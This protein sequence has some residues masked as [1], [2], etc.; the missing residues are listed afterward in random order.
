MA[1]ETFVLGFCFLSGGLGWNQTEL[2]YGASGRLSDF[3]LRGGRG[4]G[5]V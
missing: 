4:A 5:S 3:V 1:L 2:A